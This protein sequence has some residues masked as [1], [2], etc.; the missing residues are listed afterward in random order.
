VPR[1]RLAVVLLVPPPVADEVDGLRR[2][3]GDPALGRVPPHITLVPPVN[4]HVELVPDVLRVLRGA[5]GEVRPFDLS[6]GPVTTFAPV[7]PTLH[8]AVTDPAGPYADDR[9]GGLAGVGLLH[10]R[11]LAGPLARRVDHEFVPHVTLAQEATA[12]R[13]EA[14][15]AALGSYR[16]TI[17]L[18]RLHLMQEERGDD[19]VRR[20]WPVADVPF[21]P[22][23][24]VG[25]GG[26]AVELTPSRLLD[27][28]AR[29]VLGA[30]GPVAV[31]AGADPLV[32]TAR[33][34]GRA[35]GVLTGWTRDDVAQLVGRVVVMPEAWAR[36]DV[37]AHLRAAFA[38]AAADRG[39]AV[40]E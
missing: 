23:R 38:S 36:E 14:A 28:E 30:Q 18:D 2:A 21:G 16:S 17:A 31:P 5:A 39:C 26:F 11:C 6:L 12:T 24:V 27:P 34:E 10:D 40:A 25:R 22:V 19:G 15:L 9:R 7:T 33:H 4:V 32:V 20:W 37:A 1:D 35:V 13:I 29:A 8:L 3:C